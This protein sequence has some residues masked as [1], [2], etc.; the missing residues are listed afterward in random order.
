MTTTLT[1]VACA[2]KKCVCYGC[3]KCD[4]IAFTDPMKVSAHRC[5]A[6]PLQPYCRGVKVCRLEGNNG[7]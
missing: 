4:D 5:V 3:R 7:R 2:T 1:I 6:V